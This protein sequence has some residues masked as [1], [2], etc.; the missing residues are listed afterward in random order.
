MHLGRSLPT[1][2]ERRPRNNS[3]PVRP[4]DGPAAFFIMRKGLTMTRLRREPCFVG[5]TDDPGKQQLMEVE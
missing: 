5:G 3:Y 2:N 1:W 4:I